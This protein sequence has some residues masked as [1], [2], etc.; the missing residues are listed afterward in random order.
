MPGCAAEN[1]GRRMVLFA[2]EAETERARCVP[3]LLRGEGQDEGVRTMELIPKLA[4]PLALSPRGE[5]DHDRCPDVTLLL[6]TVSNTV[7]V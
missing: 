4:S 3:S 2:S 5:R 7:T 6:T 1:V